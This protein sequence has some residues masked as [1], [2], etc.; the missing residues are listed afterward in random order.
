LN[1]L[2]RDLKLLI[3]NYWPWYLLALLIFLCFW[4][5]LPLGTDEQ[6][7]RYLLSAIPQLLA[8]VF[9][10]VF[11]ITLVA[12]QMGKSPYGIKTIFYNK[13]TIIMMILFISAILLPLVTLQIAELQTAYICLLEII[14]LTWINFILALTALCLLL[15][16]PY[17]LHVSN[18]IRFYFGIAHLRAESEIAINMGYEQIARHSIQE[19]KNLGVDAAEKGFEGPVINTS[20]ILGYL[21]TSAEKEKEVE[22]KES[23]MYESIA[24]LTESCF[25]DVCKVSAEKKLLEVLIKCGYLSIQYRHKNGGELQAKTLINLYSEEK[26]EEKI[27]ELKNEMEREIGDKKDLREGLNAL[28][29]FRE[30][31]KKVKNE[32]SEEK[33]K[34]EQ[35][36]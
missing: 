8:A 25:R 1:R 34:S 9:A 13:I 7:I 26:V 4:L 31:L 17:L 22:K 18:V 11:T 2:K 27:K 24:K 6:G 5:F 35:K 33:E 12:A 28:N 30:L 10:L 21:F 19:L 29:K 36:Y 15:L 32:R 3:E 20:V 14:N 23:K 16:I